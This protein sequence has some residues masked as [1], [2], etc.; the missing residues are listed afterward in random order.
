M[1]IRELIMLIRIFSVLALP[2]ERFRWLPVL[3]SECFL[4]QKDGKFL[5]SAGTSECLVTALQRR[6]VSPKK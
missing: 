6:V 1:L 5:S 2:F 3:N 4:G